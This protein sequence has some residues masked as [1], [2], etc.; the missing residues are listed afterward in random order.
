MLRVSSTSDGEP[1]DPGEQDAVLAS[2]SRTLR[3]SL[4]SLAIFF[5]LVVALLLGVPGLQTA[6]DKIS[7]ADPAWIAAGIGLELLSCVGYM[8]LFDLV[9]GRLG[10]A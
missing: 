7:D 10:G 5:A 3:N 1:E 2:Q 9:F 4:I 6:A 8:V